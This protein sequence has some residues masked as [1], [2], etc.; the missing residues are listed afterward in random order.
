VRQYQDEVPLFT[1]Y[2]IESQIETAFQRE[3]RLPAGGSIV[4]DHTEAL[5]S[6][7]INSSRSTKGADIEETALTTNLEAADEVARQL[8]LR[9]MG[10]LFVI[11]FIDMGPSRNQR[12]V[13]NRLK[14]AMKQDRARVQIGRISRFGLLEMSRQRLRPSLGESSQLVC[15]RCKGHGFIR[16][17]E[18]LAL[19]VLRVIEEQ[20]M[21]ENTARIIAHLPIDVATFLLN[22]KRQAIHDIETRQS[23]NVVLVPNS[24][25]ETPNYEIERIRSQDLNEHDTETASYQME[26]ETDSD[27]SE[28]AKQKEVKSEEPAVKRITPATPV[29]KPTAKKEAPKP[30]KEKPGFV[31]RILGALIGNGAEAA[32]TSTAATP[33]ET[34]QKQQE[35]GR[36]TQA[37]SGG[38]SRRRPARARQDSSNTEKGQSSKPAQSRPRNGN[39]SQ[40]QVRP[41][42]AVKE[43]TD[44]TTEG[45]TDDSSTTTG[46]QQQRPAGARR[47]RRGGRRRRGRSTQGQAEATTTQQQQT[48]EKPAVEQSQQPQDTQNSEQSKPEGDASRPRSGNRRRGMRR[49]RSDNR[50]RTN[51]ASEAESSQDQTATTSAVPSKAA[52]DSKPSAQPVET[53]AKDDTTQSSTPKPE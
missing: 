15:P 29:P 34:I 18:S 44:V 13:E 51:T 28:Q 26:V 11:D 38:G 25:F 36:R 5:T 9:D 31:K 4:I 7:D 43:Q 3:V 49:P 10:G 48:E 30:S 17:V 12:A 22:E 20:A 1:R 42:E 45:A 24:N 53:K 47:G 14:E 21:K 41:N 33:E 40:Q 6:V 39:V 19:S 23:V 50:E 37:R 8:R 32:T 52:S 16:G 27:T 46:D 2:Q 35:S